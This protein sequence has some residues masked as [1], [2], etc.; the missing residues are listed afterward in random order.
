MRIG[1]R[2]PST[3]PL[4]T[5]REHAAAHG[6]DS[7]WA[8]QAPGGWDPLTLLPA[9][10]GPA[11][12][13]TAIVPTYP[14]HPVVMATEALTV[15]ALTG[16]RLTLGIGPSHE[17]MVTGWWGIPYT[18][19]ASHTREYLEVLLPLLRGEHVKHS[20]EFF[21]VDHRLE[22]TAPPPPVLIS[23]LGPRMLEI[24][25][26]LAGGTI[27]VWVR[28]DLVENYLVPRLGPGQRVVATVMV[29]ITGDPDGVRDQVARD[30]AIVDELPAYRTLL[31]RGGLSGP[32]DTVVAGDEGVV[33]RELRRFRDAGVT[34]LIIS[35]LTAPDRLLEV[36]QQAR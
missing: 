4:D 13:G 10:D 2:L 35:P 3:G 26:D 32:A 8:N 6:V 27:V 33:L 23:A 36:A 12:L 31:D 21:T 19:P 11:E 25:R 29:A 28:P 1:F 5:F 34:D 30:M 9:V 14:R 7:A 18:K 16:G 22:V 20:G 15:Q 24:A 17:H